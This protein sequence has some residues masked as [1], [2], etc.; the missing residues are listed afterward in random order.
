MKVDI[1]QRNQPLCVIVVM[2]Y[3]TFPL[4]H[5]EWLYIQWAWHCTCPCFG[6][7]ADCINLLLALPPASF[8]ARLS[9]R[10]S[11]LVGPTSGGQAALLTPLNSTGPRCPVLAIIWHPCLDPYLGPYPA[12]LIG[13]LS[14]MWT[15]DQH[16]PAGPRLSSELPLP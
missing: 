1:K 5:V 3:S 16:R 13:S 9:E 8:L 7:L 6:D 12:R 2:E 11:V 10:L 15:D 14:A 4:S